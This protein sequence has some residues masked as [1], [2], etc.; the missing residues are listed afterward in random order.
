LFSHENLCLFSHENLHVIKINSP[1]AIDCHIFG[2]ALRNEV[3]FSEDPLFHLDAWICQNF[4]ISLLERLVHQT[5]LVL[6]R[7][8][9]C[10][11]YPLVHGLMLNGV[12]VNVEPW[13]LDVR[14]A[15]P[16]HTSMVNMKPGHLD[17]PISLGTIAVLL[18]FD[19]QHVPGWFPF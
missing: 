14:L 5:L 15:T 13:H 6:R 8:Q 4:L 3:W 2:D 19:L 1:A 7:F 17:M 16:W 18:P 9:K 12:F 10:G 11:G